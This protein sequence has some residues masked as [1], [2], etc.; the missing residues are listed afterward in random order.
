MLRHRTA[1]FA[2]RRQV[3]YYKADQTTD[4]ILKKVFFRTPAR[5][6]ETQQ[7]SGAIMMLDEISSNQV[8]ECGSRGK[9][10]RK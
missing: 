9:D 4:E 8:R 3:A 5:H 2:F 1:K 7:I 10:A 6:E